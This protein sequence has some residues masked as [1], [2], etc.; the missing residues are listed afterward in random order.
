[1]KISRLLFSICGVW[2]MNIAYASNIIDLMDYSEQDMS[3]IRKV[4]IA[5]Y[6]D[7]KID[8]VDRLEQVG[9]VSRIDSK[10]PSVRVFSHP[11]FYVV[12]Y[13]GFLCGDWLG[14]QTQNANVFGLSGTIQKDYAQCVLE[15]KEN[16]RDLLQTLVATKDVVFTGFKEGG[17]LA[18]LAAIDTALS[19]THYHTLGNKNRVKVVTF[20]SASVGDSIFTSEYKMSI[21]LKNSIAFVPHDNYPRHGKSFADLGK[22]GIPIR[23]LP[24]ESWSDLYNKTG[25]VLAQGTTVITGSTATI[26]G[27]LIAGSIAI[28]ATIYVAYKLPSW[29]GVEPYGAPS[30]QTINKAF[31]ET[32]LCIQRLSPEESLELAGQRPL[33]GR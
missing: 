17:A 2:L 20:N 29:I 14:G 13:V 5:S 15:S 25:A 4:A 21:P 1:M 7:E 19:F 26:L 8:S 28:P 33:S 11:N 16:L 22:V 9:E 18:S 24:S 23:I 30:E 6:R 12:G 27:G 10:K 32:K 3:I 31:S